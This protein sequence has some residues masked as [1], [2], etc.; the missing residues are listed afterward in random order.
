MSM[1]KKPSTPNQR[2]EVNKDVEVPVTSNSV[3]NNQYS[4]SNAHAD[5]S[6]GERFHKA[7]RS[8]RPARVSRR[9]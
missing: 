8:P 1:K 7:S 9:N 3:T 4:K 2:I 6:L 5:S